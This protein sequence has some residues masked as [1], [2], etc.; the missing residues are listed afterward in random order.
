MGRQ[1]GLLVRVSLCNLLGINEYR[2][3]KDSG[4]KVRYRWMAVLWVVLLLMMAGYVG[5]LSYGLIYMG[6]GF[7]VPAVLSMCVSMVVFIFT[8]LK[9]GAV[10]FDRSAYEKQ[11]ALPVSVRAIIVSRFLS[12]YLTNM[13][14]GMLVMFPGMAV[15]GIMERPKVTFYLYGIL[16]SVFLPL[17]PLTLASVVGAVISGISSRWR[18]KNLVAIVLTLIFICV[19]MVGSFGMA[20]MEEELLDM[21]HQLAPLMEEQIRRIYPL[22]IWLSEAMVGGKF[23]ML[24]CFLALSLGCFVLFLEILRPFY[25]AIC[26]LLCAHGAKGNYQMKEMKSRAVLRSMVERELRRYFSSV[27]YVSNTI[28]GNLLMVLVAVG[29]LIAGKDYLEG[30]LG[31]EGVVD[32]GLPVLL[33]M[34]AGLMPMSSCSISMEG[35]QWW[36]LQTFPITG[37]NLIR[38][39]VWADVLVAVPFYLVTEVL[40][41]IALRPDFLTLVSLLVMPAVYIVY[42]AVV[43]ITV[44]CKFPLLEWENEVRVVKQSASTMITMLI[45]MFTGIVPLVIVVIG[46]GLPIF[47]VNM[48]LAAVLIGV[49]VMLDYMVIRKIKC[50]EAL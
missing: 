10:L 32:R 31:I 30:M 3:T 5:A 49:T 24:L 7:Y 37:K 41:L 36:M 47:A 15:Y 20:E 42:S 28:V 11:I 50:S 48:V 43:G 17:L 39:K 18:R 25:A 44:N 14:L 4:K 2:Y 34:M 40:L 6:M 21:I 23:I 8:V 35:K 12:M 9:T 16:G 22:G 38:S 29:V 19:I 26:S 1:I 33:G 27:I 45:C 13:L 46:G